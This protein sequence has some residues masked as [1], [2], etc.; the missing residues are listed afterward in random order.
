MFV[1]SETMSANSAGPGATESPALLSLLV[2]LTATTG[3][4]DA[5]SVLGLGR[6]FTANMTGN[7]VFL[8]FALVSVPEY[9]AARSL[10]SLV[11]FLTGAVL[12]GIL[13][14]RLSGSRNRWLLMASLIESGLFLLAGLVAGAYDPA[15]LEPSGLLYGLIVTTAVAM[16][17]RNATVRR[18]G[19]ADMT[20][21][22]LTL[23][24]TDLGADS[25]LTG[26]TNP[27]WPRRLASVT[28]MLIGA[29]VGALLVL[30]TGLALPLF[31]S[32]ALSLVASVAY[33]AH[34]TARE[35]S[36]AGR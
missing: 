17:L 8:A 9:S 28:A 27:R 2:I 29:A 23:T 11:A 15:R 32:G 22:V 7:V 1:S 34:P 18:L 24:L 26:G 25:T 4:V 10:A 14:T 36:S 30:R 21:T 19:I 33:L 3:L 6:V 5:V 16:G 13:A 35:T 31:L 12:G 20:T